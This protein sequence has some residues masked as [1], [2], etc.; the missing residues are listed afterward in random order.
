MKVERCNR[1]NVEKRLSQNL[2]ISYRDE[3]VWCIRGKRFEHFGRLE[4]WRL[5]DV[6]IVRFCTNL[7]RGFDDLTPAPCGLIGLRHDGTNFDIGGGNE[8]LERRN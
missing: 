5:I 7:D 1:W 4:L 8:C 6:D 2:A 3:K